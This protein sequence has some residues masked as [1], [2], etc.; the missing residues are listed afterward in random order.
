MEKEGEEGRW[1]RKE[2]RWGRKEGKEGGEGK[3]GRKEG[4]EGGH[5]DTCSFA[6]IQKRTVLEH[7]K[8]RH[9]PI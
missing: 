7:Q 1:G 3:R 8:P 9:F 5:I 4:K 2:R 6:S